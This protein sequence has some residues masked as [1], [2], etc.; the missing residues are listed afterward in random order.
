MKKLCMKAVCD[1]SGLIIQIIVI[2]QSTCDTVRRNKSAVAEM[3]DRKKK[4]IS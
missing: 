2:R 4:I 1:R 3:D